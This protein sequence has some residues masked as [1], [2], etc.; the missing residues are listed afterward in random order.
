MSLI[1]TIQRIQQIHA[2]V[3]R[4]HVIP[5]SPAAAPFQ[6]QLRHAQAAQA[7]GSAQRP[8]EA[9][10]DISR[11]IEAAAAR[12]GVDPHLVRAVVK[13]ESN[14]NPHAT[15]PAGAMGLMQLMPATARSLGVTDPYDPAQNL[16]GGVRYLAQ[17]LARF[18]GN[19][20]L[21]LAAYNAG[22]GAVAKY[23]GVPPYAETQ[24]YVRAVMG[25]YRAY[26]QAS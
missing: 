8:D 9:P 19:L 25:M 22:P 24:R 10:A 15:S 2:L 20:E 26:K 4:P 7:A 16:E 6:E 1:D 17:M 23:G 3:H 5:Q 11:L 21:A 13:Q 14:F 18:D 12:H